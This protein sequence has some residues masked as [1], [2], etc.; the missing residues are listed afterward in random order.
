MNWEYLIEKVVVE[1]AVPVGFSRPGDVQQ[2][3]Q[4][5]LNE[6]GAL[7]WELVSV[8]GPLAQGCNPPIIALLYLKRQ[9]ERK[10]GS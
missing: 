3:V 9:K 5:R 10:A 1:C 4:K 6:L 7:G 2:I 8:T